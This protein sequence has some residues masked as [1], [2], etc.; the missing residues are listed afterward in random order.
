MSLRV[1]SFLALSL[2]AGAAAAPAASDP[3]FTY[4]RDLAE[5]RNYTLG[6]PVSPKLTPDGRHALF[7]RAQPRDPTLRLF[8]VELSTGRERELLTPEQLLAGGSETLSAEEKARR[9]RQRQSLKG[10]T[11]FQLSTDGT[12]LLVTLSGRLY[13]VERS[14]AAVTALPGT[15]WVDPRFSPDG[16]FVAA[17]GA[18]RELHVIDLASRPL[19]ARPVT[20]GATATLSHG[21]AE[22]V[23]QEEMSRREGY[24][25]SPDASTLLVQETDESAVETRYVADPLQPEVPPTKFFYP[26]AGTPNAVVRLHLVPRTGGAPRAVAWDHAAFPYLAGVLWPARAPLTILVQNREQT[27]QRLLAVNPTDG[28]THELVRETDAAWLNLDDNFAGSSGLRRPPFW[29]KD[30]S[31]FLWT[32]ERRGAWQVELRDA[33]GRFVRELT[34]TAWT[35]RGLIGLDETGQSFYV[36]G[37]DDAREVHVWK[38]PLAGGPGERLTRER[39]LHAATFFPESRLLLRTIDAFDGAYRSEIVAAD[40]A[41]VVATLRSLAESP[42]RWPGTELTRTS[43]PRAFDAAITRPRDA[44]PG[45]TYPVLLSVY[46][47][48]TSKR[49]TADI[50]GFLPDQWMADQGYIVVRLDGRG[51]PGRGRE[52][53]RVVKGNLIDVALEDQIAGLQALARERPEL[54]LT[55][56]GVTGWSFGGY[57]AAMAAIRRPDIF[58]CAVVGAPVVT[59]E[60]Y[61][62]HYTERYLGLP[63]NAPEAYRVSNVTTYAAQA[64]RPLLLI[65]GLTDDNVYFQH[66]LQ[67]ADALFRAGK[68]YELMPMLGTHM[69]SDPNIRLRQQLRIMEFFRRE[70]RPDGPTPR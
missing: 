42:A 9:E 25:W 29:F 34:S 31:H 17:A 11:A 59:W 66:T 2:V 7:L 1:V 20:T 23:A 41:R 16:R 70:L 63:Q 32:T 67:L 52:W 19:A 28:S 30:G 48:P 56:V 47:G 12:R 36:R 27:D 24:W 18:D 4:F 6:R 43:G 40:D 53:E 26:R 69:V 5:T 14:T 15:G 38:F 45:R 49:V 62:T 44:T 3:Q 58:R 64:T 13:L 61:D 22:F 8:E 60:N 65:H 46:A 51:T 55:R 68:T 39:G 57:F 21:T 35:Y 10:F 54:D 33:S 37:G 50:R